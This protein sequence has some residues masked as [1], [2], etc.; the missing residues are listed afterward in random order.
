MKENVILKNTSQHILI[1][2]LD[3]GLGHATR[4]IPIIKILLEDNVNITI[5]G[6][7]RSFDLLKKEFPTLPFLALPA[8]DIRYFSTNMY[9]NIFFQSPKILI[10]AFKEHTKVKEFVKNR[11]IDTI[12]SDNRFGCFTKSTRNIF[13]THQVN[14]KI[15]FKPIQKIVN[16]INQKVIHLFDECWVPDNEQERLAGELSAIDKLNNAH[17]IGLLSRMEKLSLPVKWDVVAV[18][19]GPEPQRSIFEKKIIEQAILLDEKILIIRGKTEKNVHQS[20]SENVKSFSYLTSEELNKVMCAARIILC[21]SGYSSLMD[22]AAIQKKA[23]LI[24]TPG[25]TEQEY[26]AKD[27]F[28][29]GIFYTQKQA[30]FNLKDALWE[31]NT[32]TGFKNT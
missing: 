4:C 8:Y 11:Q 28:E 9:L 3:W 30:D 23:I 6:N 15:A 2:P 31:S 14:I 12:I 1:A 24:P 13:I 19:S 27:L 16:F 20:L 18:L 29:K 7:G 25:Q 26:L 21:R 32:F 5:A 10:A 17:Y 22:L